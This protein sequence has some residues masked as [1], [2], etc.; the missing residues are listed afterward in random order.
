MIPAS[1][2]PFTAVTFALARLSASPKGALGRS[3]A[4]R[5]AQFRPILSTEREIE[6][7]DSGPTAA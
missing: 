4:F 1:T 7:L 2:R 3:A 5:D 6:N